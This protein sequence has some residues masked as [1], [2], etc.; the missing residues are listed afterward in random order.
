[1]S[2]LVHKGHETFL[3]SMF[4]PTGNSES[5]EGVVLLHLA[6][7][8]KVMFS[9]S[10]TI[11]NSLKYYAIQLQGL[12][13]TMTKK[14]LNTLNEQSLPLPA[15]HGHNNNEEL[16]ANVRTSISITHTDIHGTSDV[17]LHLTCWH[18]CSPYRAELTSI[19]TP[20]TTSST[21]CTQSQV[22][23]Q[24]IKDTKTGLAMV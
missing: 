7:M 22:R 9:L 3:L 21:P 5:F 11:Y 20:P 15:F 19:A 13:Q 10:L 4:S 12:A 8:M 18:P 14:I 6:L 24:F 23:R 2:H 17:G 1:M 16:T